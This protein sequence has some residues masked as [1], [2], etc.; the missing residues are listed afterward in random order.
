MTLDSGST[1]PLSDSSDVPAAPAACSAETICRCMAVTKNHIEA[2]IARNGLRTVDA[3]T[4]H[5]S[6]GGACTGCH[7]HIRRMLAEHHGDPTLA[8]APRRRWR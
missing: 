5:T 3:V 4:E 1:L 8:E 7:R 2:A 6:A